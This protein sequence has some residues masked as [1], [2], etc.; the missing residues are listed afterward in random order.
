MRVD[1]TDVQDG[2]QELE[3]GT[4]EANVTNIEEKTSQAGNKYL[5]WEFTIAGTQQ[6]ALYITVLTQN[7]LWNLKKLLI[8]AFGY[9]KE[10]V[11]GQIDIEPVDFIGAPVIL[12]IEQE[13]YE[14]KM[15]ARVK[16]VLA[17]N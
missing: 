12:K 11:S 14:G 3:P 9:D 13:E 15:R 1:F 17:A 16:E 4:Y 5:N 2:F 7:S 6:K 10:A 8:E